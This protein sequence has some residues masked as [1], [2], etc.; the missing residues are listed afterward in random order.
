MLKVGDVYLFNYVR[1]NVILVT[2]ALYLAMENQITT[3]LSS[4]MPFDC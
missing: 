3:G 2:H 4:A 1:Q